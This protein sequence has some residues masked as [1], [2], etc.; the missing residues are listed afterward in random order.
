M[1]IISGVNT[2]KF[3]R[4]DKNG[5]YGINNE[6]GIDGAV[7]YPSDNSADGKTALQQIDEKA[8]FALTWEGLKVTGED[9]VVARMGKLDGSIFKIT[10][11]D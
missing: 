5:I 1:N 10:N 8:T 4:F 2:K 3:V 6:P 9:G 7:W 11:E